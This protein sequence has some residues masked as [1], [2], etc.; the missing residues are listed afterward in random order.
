MS[1]FRNLSNAF[2]PVRERREATGALSAPG[3]EL[4][5]ALNGDQYAMVSILCTSLI[6]T[7]DFAGAVDAAGTTYASVVA[8]P[9]SN[10]FNGGSIPLAG[11]PLVSDSIVAAHFLR[12]YAVPVA[13]LRSLRVRITSYTSGASQVTITSDTNASQ[14]MLLQGASMPSTLYVTGTAAVSTGVTVTLPAVAG[15][16]H[17]I[18]EVAVTR[19]ATAALTA[20]ATPVVVTTTNLPGTPALTFGSD[21]GGIGVDVERRL[22]VGLGLSASA[23]NTA[24]TIVAPIWTGVIWRINVAYHLGL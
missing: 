7:I 16:R 10:M 2:V 1:L 14:H 4:V 8:Y 20:S 22:P 6:A 9:I 15:L 23:I 12:V 5:L 18:D 13:Q 24:T 17:Y 11:Q 21:A 19:S 3:A